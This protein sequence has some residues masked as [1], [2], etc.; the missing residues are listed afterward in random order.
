[1]SGPTPNWLPRCDLASRA[2]VKWEKMGSEESG[3]RS[4]VHRK[5]G[6]GPWSLSRSRGRGMLC[7]GRNESLSVIRVMNFKCYHSGLAQFIRNSFFL[8]ICTL[9]A[10]SDWPWLHSLN[11]FYVETSNLLVRVLP[12]L[13]S[14]RQ[15]GVGNGRGLC[16]AP[17]SV[18]CILAAF[19]I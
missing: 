17:D 18:Q 15:S 10:F 9:S 14:Q 12:V 16:L 1:M 4:W 5:V 2:S 19:S 6:R 13:W 7:W 8:S 3:T 11:L